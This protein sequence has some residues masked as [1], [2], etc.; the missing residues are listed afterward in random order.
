MRL[1]RSSEGLSFL[2]IAAI[3]SLT[4]EPTA[5]LAMRTINP[6]TRMNF[7]KKKKNTVVQNHAY[8]ETLSLFMLQY[9]FLYGYVLKVVTFRHKVHL[10]MVRKDQVLV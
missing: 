7:G 2:N 8:V 1:S 6:N 4:N 9:N 3:E 5:V 10:V